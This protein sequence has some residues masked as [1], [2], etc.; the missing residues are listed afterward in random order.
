M[1]GVYGM[2]F[3][4]MPGLGAPWGFEAA[5]AGMVVMS[6]VLVVL[7]KRHGWL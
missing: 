1:A 5:I 6:A 2:N 4:Q 3:V 7:F